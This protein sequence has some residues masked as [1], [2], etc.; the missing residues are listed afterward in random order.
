MSLEVTQVGSEN[1]RTLK[2][3]VVNDQP[4]KLD[5]LYKTFQRD[6]EVYKAD[7]VLS[8]LQI[9]N[10]EGEMAVII[11]EQRMPVMTGTEFFSKTVEPFK[12]RRKNSTLLIVP[13]PLVAFAARLIVAGALKTCPCSGLVIWTLICDCGVAMKT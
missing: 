7:G 1:L 4:D 8:A 10:T 3:M 2:L 5:L 11:C 6:F 12:F 13:A 9:L